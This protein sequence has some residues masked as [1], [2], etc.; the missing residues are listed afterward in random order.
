MD[1]FLKREQDRVLFGLSLKAPDS[2]QLRG[3]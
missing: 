2:S 3:T 1:R